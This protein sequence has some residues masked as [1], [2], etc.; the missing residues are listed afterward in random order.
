MS[1]KLSYILGIVLTIII[2][3]ILYI[4]LFVD[5]FLKEIININKLI[6]ILS[7]FQVEN[8]IFDTQNTLIAECLSTYGY[9]Y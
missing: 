5:L 3:T 7:L 6:K 4:F 9:F 1:K 2:G 8:S